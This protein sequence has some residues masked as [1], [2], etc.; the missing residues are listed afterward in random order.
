[1]PPAWPQKS[2]GLP[3]LGPR[4]P[5]LHRVLLRIHQ[6]LVNEAAKG[7]ERV[8]K[9]LS[10]VLSRSSAVNPW[11]LLLPGLLLAL[12]GCE[13]AADEPDAAPPR[14]ALVAEV[15]SADA[16]ALS[17]VGEVRAAQRAELSFAVSGV[18]S[19]VEVDIGAKLRKGD[20][21]AQLDT[22]PLQAQVKAAEAEIQRAQ[23]QIA[24]LR[25]RVE[26]L[27]QA[28]AADAASPA[29]W[30]G[31][32]AELAA[33][34]AGLKAA[35]AQRDAAAWSLK[36]ADLRAPMAGVLASR[37]LEVGQAVAPG[38]PVLSVDGE[39]RELLLNVP[40]D[41]SVK[42]GQAVTLLQGQQ[43]HPSRVLRLGE[44]LQAGGLRQLHLAA[45]A[46]AAVGSTWAVKLA[47]ATSAE[48]A[49]S[50][51]VPLR[52]VQASATASKARVLRLAADGQRVEAVEVQLGRTQG[53]WVEV[54]AGLKRGDRVVLAGAHQLQPGSRVKPVHQLGQAR[55]EQAP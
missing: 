1:M 14:P 12:S 26:R 16:G 15:R 2:Q 54:S 37:S 11:V 25:L 35:Q 45:P 48:S 29:E 34:E 4:V 43:Q 5:R 49:A 32:Q 42:V 44:R 19:R 22:R 47:A 23:A 38:A 55:Q 7:L 17:F 3:G 41:L 31:G 8:V 6:A 27:R 21:L 10:F 40:E 39:G 52:A 33:A 50:L 9:S 24:E 30:T 13:D 18:L 36:H 20:L 46:S 53:D 28:K 51:Q